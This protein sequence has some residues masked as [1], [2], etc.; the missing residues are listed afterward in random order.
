MD[1]SNQQRLE[2]IDAQGHGSPEDTAR[3]QFVVIMDS[4]VAK[5]ISNTLSGNGKGLRESGFTAVADELEKWY[6]QT[7]SRVLARGEA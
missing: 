1:Y 7:V 3:D 2:Q 4:T 5:L 6:P